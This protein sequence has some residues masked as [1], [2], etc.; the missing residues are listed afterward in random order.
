MLGQCIAVILQHHHVAIAYNPAIARAKTWMQH[1]R[2]G[3]YRDT[4]EIA[5]RFAVHLE[6]KGPTAIRCWATLTSRHA[7]TRPSI[8]PIY[9]RPIKPHFTNA[10]VEQ[11][12]R[13]RNI[14]ISFALASSQRESSTR[15]RS[16][17]TA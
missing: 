6:C 15:L 11:S 16:S 10:R 9:I 2:D 8:S 4:V 5:R 17:G 1:L 7:M 14:D 3:K 12:M 13:S